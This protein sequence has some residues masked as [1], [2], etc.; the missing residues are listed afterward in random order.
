M[1]I[2]EKGMAT[3]VLGVMNLAVWAT[4]GVYGFN[5]FL[6]GVAAVFTFLSVV[7]VMQFLRL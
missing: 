3:L 6:V 4:A 2:R 7:A 1:T 5:L